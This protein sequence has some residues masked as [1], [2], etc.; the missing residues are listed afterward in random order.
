VRNIAPLL[1]ASLLVLT[2]GGCQLLEL[3]GRSFDTSRAVPYPDGCAAYG[4]STRRCDAIVDWARDQLP[5][6][7]PDIRAIELAPDP[8]PDVMRTQ[9]FAA[10]V[11]F[12]M[13]DGAT[14]DFPLYCGIGGQ[15]SILCTDTPEIRISSPTMGGYTDVPC[16]GEAPNE[17]ATPLPTFEPAAAK[18]ARPLE[19]AARDIPIDHV[20]KY[21]I[22]LG[23]AV[24][25]NGILT[26]ARFSLRDPLTQAMSVGDGGVWL[27]VRPVDP[28]APPF[29]NYYVRG[30][31]EGTETVNAVLVFEITS[32]E[33][34]AMLELRNIDVH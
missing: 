13:E 15:W 30:W 29:D 7:H 16:P 4:F 11:R 34:G 3:P 18:A 25:P 19:I 14:L 22:P 17:C 32:F 23:Q 26:E 27:D 24:L 33:T 31:H 20:G 1:V 5:A 12:W 8:E 21:E 10:L 9:S 28:N 6:G 2:S